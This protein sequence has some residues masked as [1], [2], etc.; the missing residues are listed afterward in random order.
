[1]RTV[2]FELGGQTLH[3]CL[4]G[5]ALYDIYDRY[6]TDE[7]VLSHIQGT[8]KEHFAAACWMLTKLAEQGELVHRYQGHDKGFLATEHWVRA[9]LAPLDVIRAKRA[10]EETVRM[11]FRLEEPEEAKPIDKGLLELEKQEKKTASGTAGAGMCRRGPSF[12]A[13]LCGRRCCCV[14]DG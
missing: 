1:M 3:L 13:F 2:P 12:W 5:A 10:I 14:R 4:N 11:G 7:P 8:G 6:G 9:N